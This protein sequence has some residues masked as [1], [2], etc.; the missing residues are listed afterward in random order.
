[1]HD[2]IWYNSLLFSKIKADSSLNVEIKELMKD[3]DFHS[4]VNVRTPVLLE[5]N[6]VKY[7]E[8][9]TIPGLFE[10]EFSYF[11][12]FHN[13]GKDFESEVRAVY[14][15]EYLNPESEYKKKLQELG[16]FTVINGA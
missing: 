15:K 3:N 11:K 12:D 14:F 6:Y 13:S 9:R 10:L 2:S 16:K 8:S 1:M 7:G 5:I 4:Y